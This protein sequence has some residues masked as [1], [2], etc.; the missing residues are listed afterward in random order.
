VSDGI[1]LGFTLGREGDADH[2]FGCTAGWSS[3]QAAW[4]QAMF[5]GVLLTGAVSA[6]SYCILAR[7]WDEG[8]PQSRLV[9]RS[10][11]ETDERPNNPARPGSRL[12]LLASDPL[13]WVGI[14]VI[15]LAW[16]MIRS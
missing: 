7:R 12:R 3:S 8:H 13:V 9:D 14:G 6:L 16:W 5:V 2:W 1:K 4:S 11:D 15:V 10:P